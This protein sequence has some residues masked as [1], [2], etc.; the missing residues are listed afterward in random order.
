VI[1]EGR[2][3]DL[4]VL[5]RDPFALDPKDIWTAEVVMTFLDGEPVHGG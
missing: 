1:E 3:A 2:P 5:D 4:V